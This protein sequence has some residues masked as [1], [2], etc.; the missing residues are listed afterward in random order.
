[1]RKFVVASLVG[2]LILALG[3]AAYSQDFYGTPGPTPKFEF[4]VFG[5]MDTITQL[6]RN[7]PEPPWTSTP[8]IF[9]PH[10]HFLPDAP[11]QAFNKTHSWVESRMR[12]RFDASMGKE[13]KGTIYLEGDSNR[14]GEWTRTDAAQRNQMGQ[15]GADRAAVEIK[16][17]YITA[18]V[19][20][21][22]F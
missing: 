9:G 21:I 17:A 22:P 3:P 5:Y 20:Y 18:A 6:N 14:W 16:N 4:K 19:P 10:L 13:L 8:S 2:F 1:M 7:V 11:Q 12:L 15:W